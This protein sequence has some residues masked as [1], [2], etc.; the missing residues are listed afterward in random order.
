M[1]DNTVYAR[2]R[3]RG[4]T[5]REFLRLCA[6]A[7]GLMGL[8]QLPPIPLE[9]LRGRALAASGV[10]AD[11][12]RAMQTKPRLP[13]VWLAYQDCA[14]CTEA[15][16]RTQEP[17]ATTVLGDVLSLE[18]HETLSAA[19]GARLEAHR[20]DVMER[21]A[22]E[23]LLVVEGSLPSGAERGFCTV[24]GRAAT[25]VLAEAADG[26]AA[27]LA[28]GNCA[29]YGG[30]PAAAPN[31]TAASSVAG[32]LDGRTV[33]NVP[34]CPAIPEVTVGTLLHYFTYDAFPELDALG[35]PLTHYGATVHDGCSR[36]RHFRASEFARSFDD[37][38]ARAGW[39]L[40]ELG[41]RGPDTHNACASRKWGVGLSWPVE[42]GHPCLGCS[43]PRFWDEPFYPWSPRPHGAFL[44]HAQND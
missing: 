44:P 24:G 31:P 1:D 13:V 6:G 15:L 38:G 23:Y 14:G 16:L 35:R 34:G 39:C 29:A 27:V 26:A 17:L 19:A 25:D 5:R 40:Y 37:D 9:P 7:V 21:F 41:C 36:R 18:Y 4:L 12:A 2:L 32:L 22:G 42:S 30:L 3:A 33:V 8:R 11:V 43:E 20:A 28:T 10:A